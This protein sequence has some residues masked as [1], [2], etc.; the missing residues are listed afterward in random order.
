MRLDRWVLLFGILSILTACAVGS[1][2]PSAPAASAAPALGAGTTNLYHQLALYIRQGLVD[3]KLPGEYTLFFGPLE[4]DGYCRVAIEGGGGVTAAG[5]YTVR[6][7]QTL[8]RYT[9]ASQSEPFLGRSD[10]YGQEIDGYTEGKASAVWSL[11][12][13]TQTPPSELAKFDTPPVPVETVTDHVNPDGVKSGFR[14]VTYHYADQRLGLDL[15][16]D[17]PQLGW[18]STGTDQTIND[19]L[20]QVAVEDTFWPG[21]EDR[22]LRR[23]QSGTAEVTYC[24]T[25][26]DEQYLSVRFYTYLN[27]RGTAHPSWW[28]RG[29]TVDRATGA[30]LSLYDV[31]DF[32]GDGDALLQGCDWTPI[33]TYDT[34]RQAFL[35]Q[36]AGN[37]QDY[38]GHISD[39]YLTEDKLG[40]IVSFARYYTLL[41]TDLDTLPLKGAF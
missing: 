33:W 31:L 32:D 12:I 1:G 27:F 25:R 36:L 3:Y 41:E 29:V 4:E 5:Y 14:R 13:D 39:F 35:D 22:G 16:A 11:D 6:W 40:L 18:H 30:R 23:E 15:M 17:Y 28:E 10:P 19:L 20:R 38:D 37:Y 7:D 34:D 9:I 21:D 2:E 24:I 26:E 8:D